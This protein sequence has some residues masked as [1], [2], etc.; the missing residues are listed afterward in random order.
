MTDAL[1]NS[2][3]RIISALSI[4]A[5]LAGITSC[6]SYRKTIKEPLKVHGTAYLLEQMKAHEIKPDYF[7]ARFSAEL[8]RNRERLAFN[9]QIRIKRDSIIW[10]TISP[11]LGL[12]M[13]RLVITND[14][15]KWMN[16]MESD[17]LLAPTEHLANM[18]HPLIEYDLLQSFI[19]GN[20]LTLYDDTQF[21]GSIDSREYKLSVA[22][23]RSLKRQMRGNE[24]IETIPVQHLWL[25]PETFRITKVSIRDLQDKD[26]G[27][28]V[29]YER[30]SE[31]NG[32]L[33]A[34]RQHYD[35]RGGGNKLK[36]QL[37]FSRLNIPDKSS[38]PFSIP[39]KY[40]PIVN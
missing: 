1:H 15:V 27:I 5:I 8:E 38:F 10:I 26:A 18:I 32:S 37:S 21:K 29:A 19:L 39:E 12:E 40:T 31:V 17:F 7:T 35:I 24:Y 13:G 33:F 11:A 3:L 25:D 30:F 36:L 4:I 16:R 20:D 2:I 34:T 22:Q 9:G 28:D 14:S 6:A 23:R